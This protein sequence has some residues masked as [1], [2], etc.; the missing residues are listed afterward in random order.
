MAAIY[1]AT[2]LRLAGRYAV[3]V[4]HAEGAAIETAVERFRREAEV[5]SA[6]RHPHII[7]VLDFNQMEDGRAY[8]VMEYL[9]GQDLRQRL[10]RE[11]TIP[12]AA[13]AVIIDQVASA[14]AAAHN[15]G[16]IH[17][18]LKPEN[19]F[20]VEVPGS[21]REFM[22]VLDFGM[23][24]IRH[25]AKITADAT[26][27]GTPPY[28]S[29]EQALGRHDEID[30]ST[31]QFALAAILYEMLTGSPAFPGADVGMV[32]EAVIERDPLPI[33][34]ARLGPAEGAIRKALSKEKEGRFPDITAFARA[35]QRS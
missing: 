17:R 4:L 10:N 23:S 18:D 27:L 14:L 9:T 22:K 26:L 15:V 8:M 29:P 20:C 3:K 24:K 35:I 5:T 21:D 31:D 1:A 30:P 28:M 6:L 19:L 7:Q 32:L 25:A 12:L 2:H 13:A 11:G 33:P 16:V 34:D